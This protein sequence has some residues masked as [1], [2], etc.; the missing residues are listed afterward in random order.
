MVRE[1][2]RYFGI[3]L[4]AAG[5]LL[6]STTILDLLRTRPDSN[7]FQLMLSSNGGIGYYNGRIEILRR[8]PCSLLPEDPK[9]P[10]GLTFGAGKATIAY[11]FSSLFKPPHLTTFTVADTFEC[12]PQVI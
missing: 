11:P 8:I 12:R 6:G 5:L 7:E 1:T 10:H 3:S 4:V 2:S 9:R